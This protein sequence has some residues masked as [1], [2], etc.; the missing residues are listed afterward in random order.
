MVA[1]E[2]ITAD[3]EVVR[4]S[5]ESHTELFWALRGGGG[6]FGVV[7]GFEFRLDR[8]GMILGG[9]LVLP[10]TADVVRGIATYA[11]EAP[12]ELTVITQV[13][14]APPAP[15]IP[16][17]MHGQLVTAVLL[18]YAGDADEGQRALAPLR[19]LATPIANVVMPMPY[20]GI[21][22]FTE[23]AS[24]PHANSVR[25]LFLDEL[26]DD[27]IATMIRLGEIAPSPIDMLQLRPLG[28]AMAR[29]PADATAFAHRDRK[30]M[31]TA[32]GIWFDPAEE[33]AN[34]AWTEAFWELVGDRA[35]GAYVNFL[36]EDGAGRIADAYPAATYERLA[37]VKR[38]YDP[39][40]VFCGNQ[41]VRA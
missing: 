21:F 38:A 8:V 12:E 19:A 35:Q 16:E 14:H 1:A 18:V 13:M 4:A 20:P 3:G 30:Y 29:V 41:N 32:I 10:A 37:A 28:G 26:D 22:Q 27:V 25:T 6:N 39:E 5:A 36:A 31:L 40:N 2:L 34:R 24:K 11:L 15:F 33:T 23:E 17:E 7:T 9:V